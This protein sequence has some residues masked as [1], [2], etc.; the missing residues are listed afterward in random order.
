MQK[1]SKLLRILRN[2]D[3]P[4]NGYQAEEKENNEN[5]K[6][7]KS[8]SGSFTKTMLSIGNKLDSFAEVEDEAEMEQAR[9]LKK[10]MATEE[11]EN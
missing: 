7:K 8:V 6:F 9:I 1:N 2:Q 11:D 4:I 10:R 5:K 3:F